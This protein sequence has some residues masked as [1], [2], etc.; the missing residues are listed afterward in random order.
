MSISTHAVGWTARGTPI[1]SDVTLCVEEGEMLGLVGPNGSGKSTLL[2][3]LAGVQRPS[4]GHVALA[5]TDLCTLRRAD[6]AR[7]IAVVEQAAE[8]SDL[9]RVRDVVELGRTPWLS[10]FS[11]WSQE[12]D[13]KV[14]GA[15]ET[16]GMAGYA[17]RSWH[18]L[19]GGE[20]QRTHIARALAQDPEVLLLDE[21]TNHLDIHH[22]LAILDLVATLGRTTVIALH[23]LNYAYACDRVGVMHG[24]RLIALGRPE[25]VLSDELI[26]RVFGVNVRFVPD[27]LDVRPLLRFSSLC[28]SAHS[29]RYRPVS[30]LRSA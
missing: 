26:G 4:S 13:R 27:P 8:T 1:V 30:L 29:E 20:R 19:S 23:D 22:Q 25:T 5:G 10:A 15:L 12:D 6:I 28:A 24:G 7:R 11:A 17:D 2:K 9:I 3:L 14:S 16:V 21:P 18:T